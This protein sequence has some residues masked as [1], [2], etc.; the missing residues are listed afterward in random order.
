MEQNVFTI[1]SLPE[2]EFRP[3]KIS[4]IDILSIST[5]MDL[6]NF[7]KTKEAYSFALENVEVK[8]GD[9]WFEVKHPGR[10]VYMPVGI[11]E[12]L[13]ALNEL[14]GWFFENIIFKSFQ[15]SSE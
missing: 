13:T 11:E 6:E 10:D 1:K 9:K 12:N 8:I 4:P 5:T 15:K 2:L 7:N 3:K 14:L